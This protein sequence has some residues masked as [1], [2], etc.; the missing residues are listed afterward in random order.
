M[1]VYFSQ[2]TD[3]L[4]PIEEDYTPLSL[5]DS[6]EKTRQALE[7][8]YA[9]FDNVVDTDLI[10]SYIYEINALQK[11]YKHL[12]QLAVLEQE[13]E[14]ESLSEHSPVRALVGHVFG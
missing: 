8:A 6:I 11:R 3:T 4:R 7:I 13:S 12:L 2:K 10:D 9:G 5:R 1:K 14:P